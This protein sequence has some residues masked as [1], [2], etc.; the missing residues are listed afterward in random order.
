M[1]SPSRRINPTRRLIIKLAFLVKLS[2]LALVQA[3]N[4]SSEVNSEKNQHTQNDLIDVNGW[5][6][7]PDEASIYTKY[8]Q[9]KP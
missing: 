3:C 1:T 2:P 4:R 8:L 9:T 6:L 7:K 5:W